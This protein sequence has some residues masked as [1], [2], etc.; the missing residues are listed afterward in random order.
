MHSKFITQK[1]YTYIL[2]CTLFF[3]LVLLNSSVSAQETDKTKKQSVFTGN[4]SAEQ[5]LTFDSLLNEQTDPYQ[6]YFRAHATAIMFKELYIPFSLTYTNKT[7][8]NQTPYNQQTYNRF[9][10]SPRYKWITVHAGWNAM[11][12]SKYSLNGHSFLGGGVE[13][14]PG[15]FKI[16]AIRGRFLKAVEQDSLFYSGNIPTYQRWGTGFQCKYTPNNNVYAVSLLQSKDIV[17]SL[18]KPLDNMNI[19][20]EENFVFSLSIEQKIKDKITFSGEFAQSHLVADSRHSIEKQT[21]ISN[22]VYINDNNIEKYN[23]IQI[24]TS[25]L[26]GKAELGIGYERVDPGYKTHGSYFF[27]NDFEN[28]TAKVSVPLFKQKL[29]LNT[30]V[31]LERDNLTQQDTNTSNRLIA[32]FNA[33]WSPSEKITVT[34]MYSNF[35]NITEFNPN[36]GLIE[37]GN[38]YDNLD[39]LRYLQI[40][41]NASLSAFFRFGSE[42]TPQSLS[43]MF[44]YMKS[45]NE[46]GI[47][48]QNVQ[49]SFY[50]GS[51]MYTCLFNES[52]WE[53]GTGVNS[54]WSDTE[55]DRYGTI[56]PTA[57]VTKRM[58]NKGMRTT[59][60]YAY[61]AMVFDE[62]EAG[63]VQSISLNNSIAIKKKHRITLIATWIERPYY[64]NESAR[65]AM[66]SKLLARLKYGFTF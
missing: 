56:G 19:Y 15:D 57:S 21:F 29:L 7:F 9:G 37:T 62:S 18:D 54:L 14:S 49:S 12:F 27:N 64:D 33:S 1:A 20:P 24:N 28:L 65:Y 48:V 50:N 11:T 23:A 22:Y 52:D 47:V 63:N 5:I 38:P 42:K 32:M 13:L 46:F 25:Y 43:T 31:G 4:V 55:I 34:G 26:L 61:N 45:I 66:M 41:E 10:M 36:A 58:F 39:S 35:R 44:S 53:I 17:A 59:V 60:S 2:F 16:R 30:S 3:A 40:N 6:V 8:S 51:M